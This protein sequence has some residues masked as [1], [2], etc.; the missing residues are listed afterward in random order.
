[1]LGMNSGSNPPAGEPDDTGPVIPHHVRAL[2]AIA[3]F[4][5]LIWAIWSLAGY[6]ATHPN[7]SPADRLHETVLMSIVLLGI[8]LIPWPRLGLSI[9]KV[10]WL[11]FEHVVAVQKKETVETVIALEGRL[12][13]VQSG[14]ANAE[15]RDILLKFLGQ[16]DRW[17]FNAQRISNW[18]SKQPGFERLAQFP[19][20][21]AYV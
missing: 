1:M 17:Y 21:A 13:N 3:L 12:A 9:K 4:I 8:L 11:E 14:D 7:A 6:A 5:P 2:L 20:V 16:Y 18:G 19:T 10:G 15:L